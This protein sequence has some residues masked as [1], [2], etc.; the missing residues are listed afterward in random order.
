LLVQNRRPEAYRSSLASVGST[1]AGTGWSGAFKLANAAS[2]IEDARRDLPAP[3]DCLAA[4]TSGMTL[5]RLFRNTQNSTIGVN[6]RF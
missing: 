3:F 6:V 1:G 2:R 4:V 5:R